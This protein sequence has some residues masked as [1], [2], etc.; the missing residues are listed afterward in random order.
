MRN[1]IEVSKFPCNRE[2]RVNRGLGV[3]TYV[4]IFIFSACAYTISLF[5]YFSP[6]SIYFCW[7]SPNFERDIARILQEQE[8]VTKRMKEFEDGLAVSKKP[9]TAEAKVGFAAIQEM[10]RLQEQQNNTGSG[11]ISDVDQDN[12]ETNDLSFLRFDPQ[13]NRMTLEAVK[14]GCSSD[15]PAKFPLEIPTPVQSPNFGHKLRRMGSW[16][17][18]AYIIFLPFYEF[19]FF[20]IL[21]TYSIFSISTMKSNNFT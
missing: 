17:Y 18:I 7:F 12:T 19:L 13:S 1:E 4:Y 14:A 5:I 11:E 16:R 2:I 8:L 20:S 21:P 6:F 15:K 10:A 3:C 9:S